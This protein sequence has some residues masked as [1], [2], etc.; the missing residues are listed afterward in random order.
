MTC[1]GIAMSLHGECVAVDNT[2][3]A[4]IVKKCSGI[5]IPRASIEEYWKLKCG[6]YIGILHYPLF[7]NIMSL[8]SKHCFLKASSN[9]CE[10]VH[11]IATCLP[12]QRHTV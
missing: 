2:L 6:K 10:E 4:E 11:E 7:P 5:L 9:C 8:K 12:I 1:I 3:A